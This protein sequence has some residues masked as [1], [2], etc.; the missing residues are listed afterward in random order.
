MF[1]VLV[2]LIR[3]IL[4][5]ILITAIFI[6]SIFIASM[7]ICFPSKIYRFILY[8]WPRYVICNYMQVIYG[9]S[10]CNCRTPRNIERNS[11]SRKYPP[12]V[13]W[14]PRQPAKNP[15][16]NCRIIK[17]Y[18][19]TGYHLAI[20]PSGRIEGLSENKESLGI[21]TNVIKY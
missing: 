8:S 17:L 14:D 4:L 10:D 3:Y 18:C 5:I 13:I 16:Y 20:T 2:K 6:S 19:R 12:Y 1:V 11:K 7:K 9:L 21:S 15:I